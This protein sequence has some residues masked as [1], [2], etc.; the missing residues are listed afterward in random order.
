L[1]S[2]FHRIFYTKVVVLF[3]VTLQFDF[4]SNCNVASLSLQTRR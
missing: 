3:D 2:I 1:F 4:N